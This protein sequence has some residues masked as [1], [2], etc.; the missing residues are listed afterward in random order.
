M[1]LG[2]K[3]TNIAII[4]YLIHIEISPIV[5]IFLTVNSFESSLPFDVDEFSKEWGQL[6]CRF[7]PTWPPSPHFCSPYIPYYKGPLLTWPLSLLQCE[8]FGDRPMSPLIFVSLVNPKVMHT[9]CII[10]VPLIP[11]SITYQ[12]EF[13]LCHLK[14]KSW[15]FET[16]MTGWS[17]CWIQRDFYAELRVDRITVK[18]QHFGLQNLAYVRHWLRLLTEF[19]DFSIFSWPNCMSWHDLR[20]QIKAWFLTITFNNVARD[21]KFACPSHIAVTF[22][23]FEWSWG[24]AS[25][26]SSTSCLLPS[27][28]MQFCV[29]TTSDLFVRRGVIY[30][31]YGEWMR[32]YGLDYGIRLYDSFAWQ[33]LFENLPWARLC[34]SKF[35]GPKGGQDPLNWQRIHPLM[36]ETAHKCHGRR[37]SGYHG[38]QRMTPISDTKVWESFLKEADSLLSF[39]GYMGICWEE[40]KGKKKREKHCWYIPRRGNSTYPVFSETFVI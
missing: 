4:Q 8:L 21:R 25:W 28:L 15:D 18:T 29:C 3:N 24:L 5:S 37:K 13:S 9:L 23:E 20:R 19:W 33:A 32:N 11:Q 36:K 17:G 22:S 1:A 12:S 6:F 2:L 26:V 7:P 16:P 14:L 27:L 31:P 30:M 34:L 10:S 35:W 38:R 40:G 39:D